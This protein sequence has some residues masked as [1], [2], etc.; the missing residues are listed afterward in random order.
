MK[1]KRQH[2][3]LIASK[4]EPGIW[5]HI[6]AYFGVI[7]STKTMREHLHMLVHLLGF[8]RP[9][10]LF[11][12]RRFL[13]EFRRIWTFIA[14]VCFHSQEAFARQCGTDGA[15]DAL[16]SSPLLPVTKRQRELLG[17]RAETCVQR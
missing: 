10:D 3:D 16:R 15:M 7:E 17:D 12:N 11:K 6:A 14:G 8:A 9:E 2:F 13:D 1:P 4:N 5:Q